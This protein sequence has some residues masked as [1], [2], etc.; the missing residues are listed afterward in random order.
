VG[1]QFVIA[2]ERGEVVP[3]GIAMTLREHALGISGIED[4]I[5]GA[6]AG[7]FLDVVVHGVEHL[8]AVDATGVVPEKAVVGRGRGC[9]RG[10]R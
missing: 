10:W 6:A 3:I 1:E 4:A 8:A 2:G 5:G 9:A 7:L